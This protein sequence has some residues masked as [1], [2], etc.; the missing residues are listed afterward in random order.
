MELS[1]LTISKIHQGLIKKE[2]SV[3][4]LAKL[5]LD[6][7]KK[8]DKE[9]NAFLTVTE[10]LALLQAKKVDEMISKGKEISILNQRII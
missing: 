10:D 8:S 2:F 4:E 6:R 5:L 9:I 7:I 3:L 1:D